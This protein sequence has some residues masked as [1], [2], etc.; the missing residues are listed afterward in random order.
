MLSISI[1]T[2]SIKNLCSVERKIEDAA[3]PHLQSDRK[4]VTISAGL[5][6]MATSNYASAEQLLRAADGAL[7]YAK[8]GGRNRVHVAP[9]SSVR[10]ALDAQLKK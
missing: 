9:E 1:Y 5:A 10:L 2:K 6:V 4:V 3:M 7:Y 8:W